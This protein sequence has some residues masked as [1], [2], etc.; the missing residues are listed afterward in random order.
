[1]SEAITHKALVELMDHLFAERHKPLPSPT[2][3]INYDLLFKNRIGFFVDGGITFFS[4]EG[5]RRA[6]EVGA[7]T[8]IET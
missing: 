8:P 4:A 1:M 5:L 6:K 3:A 2:H 7:I